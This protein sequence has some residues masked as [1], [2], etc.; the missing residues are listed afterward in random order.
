MVKPEFLCD[1]HLLGEHGELHKFIPTFRKG[2]KVNKR[3]SPIVQLQFKGYKKRH[4]IIADEM[5]K[6][7]MNHKSPLQDL[8][9]FKTIYPQYYDME[10]DVNNS[11]EDL[12]HRCEKCKERMNYEKQILFT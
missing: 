3:F 9:D 4:D 1:K 8:P 10:V 7:G 5:I 12:K 11:I 6:R 2:Y